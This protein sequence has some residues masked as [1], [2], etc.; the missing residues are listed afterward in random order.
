MVTSHNDPF[1]PP[2]PY[3]SPGSSL[4]SPGSS[5]A[6]SPR[7]SAQDGGLEGVDAREL[8]GALEGDDA[9][10]LQREL[11]GDDANEL[12]R[13]REGDEADELQ[14][15]LEE[16]DD[17]DE[18]QR[19]LEEGNEA[20]ETESPKPIPDET[21]SPSPDET[22]S[23]RPMA[24]SPGASGGFLDMAGE[25]EE[26]GGG[27]GAEEG[28]RG[29]E[30]SGGGGQAGDNRWAV[31]SGG[32]EAPDV[33]VAACERGQGG[34]AG[35]AGVE[36]AGGGQVS[37]PRSDTSVTIRAPASGG[38]SDAGD[39]AERLA[40]EAGGLG[41]RPDTSVP[42]KAQPSPP[43]AACVPVVRRPP[44]AAA[45]RA[46]RAG[47]AGHRMSAKECMA[48]IEGLRARALSGDVGRLADSWWG[49][50]GALR[51]VSRY[52]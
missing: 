12:Q 22:E 17:A 23:P 4:A 47:R 1:N 8:H 5:L 15:E 38:R 51:E 14:G 34:S 39:R 50:A 28:G 45:G 43:P 33:G 32:D 11:E 40:M 7:S 3:S 42:M 52:R 18:L 46:G 27:E 41:F 29:E 49:V 9:H 6:S 37:A 36:A 35:G 13:G 20:D 30:V 25:E 44:R 24:A 2:P 10:D 48:R 16:G 31:S 19:E 21:E 26:A